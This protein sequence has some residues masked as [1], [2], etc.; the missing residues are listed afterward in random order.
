[1]AAPNVTAAQ[2]EWLGQLRRLR[3][4]PGVDHALLDEVEEWVWHGVKSVFPR[5]PP[6]VR[7]LRNTSAFTKNATECMERLRVYSDLGSLRELSAPPPPGGHIQPLHGVVKP[8]KKA[9]VCMDLKQNY[10]DFI[11]DAPFRMSSVQHAVDMARQARAQVGKAAWMVKLD[12]SSCFLSFPIH[13]DDLKFFYCEAGGDFFQFVTLVFGRKDAP[14]VVSILLD[15]VSA[16]MADAGIAHVRYLD[17]YLIVATT[18][19]R[20]WACAHAAAG[21]LITFGLALALSKVEGP[22]QRLEFLGIIIDSVGEVL[23][24][25]EERREEL[26]VLLRGF[27]KRQSSSLV[28][29]QSLL[30]KLSFASTV[31]PGARPFLRRIIDMVKLA[32]RSRGKVALTAAFRGDVRYWR[33]HMADWN[34]RARWRAPSS[35][36]VV[37]ASDAS[38]SGFAYCME[39]CPAELARKLPLG[40]EP[41]TV[42][43]GLW[44]RENGDA[45]PQATSSE[46]Q[47]G[48]FFCPLAA[49]VEYGSLLTDQHVVF[50]IDNQS[51]VAVINR[52]RTREHRVAGLLRALCD[53][54]RAHNF[55]FAA[56]HRA[57]E[58]NVLMDW[59]SRPDYHHFAS[60]GPGLAQAAEPSAGV[61]VVCGVGGVGAFPPLLKHTSLS[62]VNSR[63]LQFGSEGNSASWASSS[64]GWWTCAATCA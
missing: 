31:L 3:A 56:V 28:R 62:C 14:R 37:F 33:H 49:A 52:L 44:S 12:I 19:T 21:I 9:R 8:G 45:M 50:V 13:E 46:I 11:P 4:L 51:D 2:K 59:F 47:W 24:I 30:G 5:G 22:L 60:S 55:T 58:D 43:M 20:A 32:M 57:G 6:P 63:C 16:A 15:L 29:L 35:K 38:T 36:P 64:G 17:D 53:A 25:S 23:A 1:M 26:L 42:R 7:R 41:G 61:D 39:Q 34:G 40:F 18:A 54:S 27:A 10:N 48:E